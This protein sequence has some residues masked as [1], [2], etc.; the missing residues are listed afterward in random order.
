MTDNDKTKAAHSKNQ[1]PMSK[2][3][4]CRK[5]KQSKKKK[6]C[7][8]FYKQQ[9]FLV[10]S[11]NRERVSKETHFGMPLDSGEKNMHSSIYTVN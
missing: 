7:R 3:L 2:L 4:D 10:K 5:K 8:V 1:S 6:N 9:M 11:Q